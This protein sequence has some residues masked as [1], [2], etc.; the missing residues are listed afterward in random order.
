MLAILSEYDIQ[1]LINI[2]FRYFNSLRQFLKEST[3][4]THTRTH[5]KKNSKC[6]FNGSHQYTII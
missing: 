1:G 3:L 5:I 4:H 2:S 6:G